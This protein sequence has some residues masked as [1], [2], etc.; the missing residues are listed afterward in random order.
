MMV[1]TLTIIVDVLFKEKK[2][3]VERL[4]RKNNLCKIEKCTHEGRDKK[5]A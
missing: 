2:S 5:N 4:D 1:L 3:H